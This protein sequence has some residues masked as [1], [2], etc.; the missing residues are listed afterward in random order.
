[1]GQASDSNGEQMNKDIL[2][3][4]PCKGKCQNFTDEQCCHETKICLSNSAKNETQTDL[5]LK[6]DSQFKVGDCVVSKRGVKFLAGI[7]P[8][9][10][11]IVQEISQGVVCTLKDS[12]DKFN[13]RSRRYYFCGYEVRHAT[14]AEIKAGHRIDESSLDELMDSALKSREQARESAVALKEEVQKHFGGGQ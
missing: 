11:F 8:T 3:Q 10:I 9:G 13:G 7:G 4:H 12:V 2:E 5:S 1:M 6:A 14:P